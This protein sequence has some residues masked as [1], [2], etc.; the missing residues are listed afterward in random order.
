MQN[1]DYERT[2]GAGYS[3]RGPAFQRVQPPG[4]AAAGTIARPTSLRNTV[5]EF[6]S[7]LDRACAV[8]F[9]Q[10]H[11]DHLVPLCEFFNM[12]L[13]MF[14]DRLADIVDRLY[15]PKVN[16]IIKTL[17][18]PFRLD[19][20]LSLRGL[21]EA[22]AEF[23]IV[24][25]SHLYSRSTLKQLFTRSGNR[26]ARVVFCPHGFSEKKQTWAAGAALQDTVLVYGTSTLDQLADFGVIQ[27][28]SRCV[29]TG[30][31]RQS[32]YDDNTDFYA[33]WVASSQ[34]SKLNPAR[35]TILYAPTWDDRVGSS[36][37][38]NTMFPIL[39][40]ISKTYNLI[41]KAH[42]HC[43]SKLAKIFGDL[44]TSSESIYLLSNTPITFPIMELADV[45]MGDMSSLAYDFL[46]FDRPMLFLNQAAGSSSDP[47]D[48]LL[49]RC[50]PTI[51]PG[52][53]GRIHELL[54]QELTTD[55]SIYA[56]RRKSL[57]DY[58]YASG[59]SPSMM[60]CELASVLRGD[61]PAWML[62]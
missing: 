47:A 17:S 5:Q 35:K 6:G 9:Y 41:I 24:F 34:L 18:Q 51:A 55:E 23:D 33:Q 61:P 27:D 13:V 45:Y 46:S 21:S 59:K 16:T 7:M 52:E 12:P 22:L 40:Q 3:A 8:A 50:G 38:Q 26:A 48:S 44:G 28:L 25:C 53:Y 32:F 20:E 30:N 39:T 14:N 19:D 54:E 36:S 4:K 29:I 10:H 56:G 11:L 31:Y 37:L 43:E 15:P 62:D 2:G 57:Y 60:C 1:E 49:F 42:P 58:V